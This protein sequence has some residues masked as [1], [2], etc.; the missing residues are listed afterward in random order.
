M[1]LTGALFF[2]LTKS[3]SPRN[4]LT[5]LQNENCYAISILLKTAILFKKHWAYIFTDD[6]IY[7]ESKAATTDHSYRRYQSQIELRN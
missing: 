5:I 1:I 2:L 6:V 7:V 3:S 4:L